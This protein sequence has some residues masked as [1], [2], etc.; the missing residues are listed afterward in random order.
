MSDRPR[1]DLPTPS[2][3]GGLCQRDHRA[4]SLAARIPLELLDIIASYLADCV[5]TGPLWSNPVLARTENSN[6][7]KDLYQPLRSCSFVCRHWA[8]ICRYGLFSQAALVFASSEDWEEFVA[9]ASS[10]CPSLVPIYKLI[11]EIRFIQRYQSPK[12]AFCHR[13]RDVPRG[14]LDGIYLRLDLR[15]PVPREF[16]PGMLSTPHWSTPPTLTTPHSLL[17]PFY[18]IIVT[19]VHMPSLSH[20]LKFIRYVA[21]TSSVYDPHSKVVNK[22]SYGPEHGNEGDG[23]HLYKLTWD[24]GKRQH[25]PFHFRS[26]YLSQLRPYDPQAFADFF[27]DAHECTSNIRLCTYA[28]IA[29][30]HCWMHWLP[31]AEQEWILALMESFED[32]FVGIT[33]KACWLEMP[34]AL[35]K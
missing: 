14:M 27:C 29:H 28:A 9:D 16:P 2:L 34:K 19:N 17:H 22:G 18:T 35:G 4:F 21:Y 30:P 6:G 33:C 32:S 26:P 23:L 20:V 13:I 11:P 15:G 31:M 7:I 3:S 12:P 1:S 10:S 5:R 8:N 25:Y 24:S